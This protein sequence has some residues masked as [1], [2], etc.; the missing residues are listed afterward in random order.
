MNTED[1]NFE[2]KVGIFV[3]IGIVMLF[4]IVFSIGKVYIFQPGYHIRVLFNF[5]GGLGDAAPVRLAGV[6]DV[7]LLRR[8]VEG[9]R[10]IDGCDEA[11][12][13]GQQREGGFSEH[14]RTLYCF[15]SNV[16]ARLRTFTLA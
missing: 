5:A 2:L 8:V 15:V 10:G 16:R 3:F 14:R 4:I 9:S 11:G 6:D 12:R 1:K 13:A 7:G